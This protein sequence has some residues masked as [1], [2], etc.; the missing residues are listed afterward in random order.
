M[1]AACLPL[2]LLAWLAPAPATA[3]IGADDFDLTQCG[4]FDSMFRSGLEAAEVTGVRASGGSGGAVGLHSLSVHVPDTGRTHTV[5]LLVPT[6]YSDA[7]AWPLVM[8]LHGAAGSTAAAGTAAVQIRDLWQPL[9]LREGVLI[10]VPVASGSQGGWV[11]GLDT[12]A[13]ACALASIERQYNVD[14]ARRHLWGFSAGAHFSHSL[15]LSNPG[16]IASYAANAGALFALACAP[17]GSPGACDVTLPGVPRRVPVS[18]RVG[19]TDPLQPYAFGDFGRFANAG[20]SAGAERQYQEF[21]GGH[22]LQMADIEAAWAWFAPR[23][24][25][26]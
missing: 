23:R 18:L 3:Q 4:A 8:A 16:R 10:V 21:S 7:S 11:P 1:R 17:S 19:S 20:W 15:A 22:T 14:R 25:S 9:A 13:L 12:P 24:L 2:A 6:H 26:P 5:L